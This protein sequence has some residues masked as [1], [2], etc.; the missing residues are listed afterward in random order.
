MKIVTVDLILELN[1]EYAEEILNFERSLKGEALTIGEKG[2]LEYK[3]IQHE[4]KLLALQDLIAKI[5]GMAK[6][7]ENK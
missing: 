2:S 5:K 1:K 6:A 4:G 7:T 3:L